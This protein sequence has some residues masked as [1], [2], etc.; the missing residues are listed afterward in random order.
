[1]ATGPDWS[2]GEYERTAERLAPIAEVV[3][4]AAQIAAGERV[5]DVA[6]GTGNAALAAA[7][8]GARVVGVDPAAGLVA[9]ATR[10]SCPWRTGP[11]T[12]RSACSA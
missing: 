7:R 6:C 10:W 4:D 8:R 5:L 11:S 2:D 12:R 3:V 1:V 9:Q